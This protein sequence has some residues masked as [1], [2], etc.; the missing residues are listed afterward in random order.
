M[1]VGRTSEITSIWEVILLNP[2]SPKNKHFGKMNFNRKAIC[3]LNNL[4]ELRYGKRGKKPKKTIKELSELIG[5]SKETISRRIKDL[6][7]GDI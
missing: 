4:R 7:V 1:R 6:K 3:F 5:V 2:A